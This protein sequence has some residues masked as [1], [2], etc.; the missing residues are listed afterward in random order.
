MP[1]KILL[2]PGLVLHKETEN[3]LQVSLNRQKNLTLCSLLPRGTLCL[4]CL[5]PGSLNCFH[6]HIEGSFSKFLWEDADGLQDSLDRCPHLLVLH[7]DK[8]LS[9]YEVNATEGRLDL[10]TVCHC[11]KDTLRKLCVDNHVCISSVLSVHLLALH[12]EQILLLI[13]N[14]VLLHL[15]YNGED[16]NPKTLSCFD[17]DLDPEAA[18]RISD[19]CLSNDILFLLDSSGIVYIYDTLDGSHVADM[20]LPLRPET[21]SLDPLTNIHVSPDLSLA[22][23]SS[24]AGW[25]LSL[26]LYEY[27]RQKSGQAKWCDEKPR[28]LP[29]SYTDKDDV[30]SCDG[31]IHEFGCPFR[32]DRS[33]EATLSSLCTEIRD[34]EDLHLYP[35]TSHPLPCSNC[36]KVPFSWNPLGGGWQIIQVDGMEE[37]VSLRIWSVS[38]F[39]AVFCLRGSDG[40]LTVVL[41]DTETQSVMYHQLGKALCVDCTPDQ[42][43]LVITDKGISLVLFGAS[44]DEFL[45][46]LMIHGSASNADTLC[47]LNNWGRCSIPIHTLEAGLENR[48]LDTVDFFLKSKENILNPSGPEDVNADVQSEHYLRNVQDLLP[49][50]DLLSSYIRGTDQETHSKHF[51][52]QLLQLTLGFL[53]G[54]LR[55]LCTLTSAPDPAIKECVRILTGYVT[56]LRPFMKR[57]TQQPQTMQVP[58][59]ARE[60][61]AWKNLS[62]EQIISDAILTNRIPEA[63]SFLRLQGHPCPGL[64]WLKQEGLKLVYRCL[65]EKCVPEACQLLRNMGFSVWSE[66]HRICMHTSER[67]VRNLLVDLLRAEGRLSEQ[68]QEQIHTVCRVEELYYN[69]HNRERGKRKATYDGRPSWKPYTAACE[70]NILE[71]V[72][73]APDHD[74]ETLRLY[75]AQGWNKDTQEAILL[76]EQEDSDLSL[77][78]PHI[79][80]RH[81]TLWHS[82]PSICSWLEETGSHAE[83]DNTKLTRWPRL[84][85][86]LVDENTM[87]CRY[88]RQK[89]LDKL[90]S[91]GMIVPS[92]MNDF[93]SLVERLAFG[94]KLMSSSDSLPSVFL[95]SMD[96]HNRFVQMCAENGLQYLLY[97]Y[98]DYYRLTPEFCSALTSPT[99]LE[100]FPWFSF[101]VQIRRIQDN[102]GDYSQ[103]FH[104]SLANAHMVMPEYLPSVSS[105]LLEGHTLLALATNMYAPGGI[106]RVL[107]QREEQ[108]PC[109]MNVDPQLLKMALAPYPKLRAALFPQHPAPGSPSHISLYH[110]LQALSPFNPT[111]FFTWQGANTLASADSRT[112]LPHCSCP[113]LVSKW[114]VVEQLDVCYYLR[115][116]RPAVAFANFLVQKLLK[117]KAPQQQ[118]QEIAK[119]VYSLALSCFNVQTVIASCVCFLELLGLSSHKLRVDVN[120]ADLILTHSTSPNDELGQKSEA[121]ALAQRMLRLV[122]NET[123]AAG[124]LSVS[125]EEAMNST[126]EKEW[127]SRPH[128]CGGPWST[129]TQFCLLHSVPLSSRYLRHCGQ[130]QDWLQLLMHT[131]SH[132]QISCVLEDLGPALSSHVALALQRMKLDEQPSC[133]SQ[134]EVDSEAGPVNLFHVMLRCQKSEKP[135]RML[136]KESVRYSAPL[137]SVLAACVQDADLISCLCVW[138]LTSV[139]AATC[140]VIKRSLSTPE[141]HVWDLSDLSWIWLNLLERKASRTLHRAFSIFMEDCPLLPLLDMYET[142]LHHKNYLSAEDKLQD[143]KRQLL[144]L[145]SSDGSSTLLPLTWIQDQVSELLKLLLL[146]SKT[147]YEQRKILQLLCDNDSQNVCGA[148]DIHKLSALTQILHDYPVCIGKEL[149]REYSEEG[150]QV[151]CQRLL[152]LLLEGKHFCLARKVAELAN[153]PADS[154]VIEEVL[155]D[156][157]LLQEIGQWEC[158][159]SRAEF[160]KKCQQMFTTNQ[161]SP[162]AASAFF[163]SQAANFSAAMAGAGEHID[164][165]AE[166]ELLLSLAGNWLSLSDCAQVASLEELEKLIWKCRIDQEVLRRNGGARVLCS[167]SPFTSLASEFSFSNLP[168]LNSPLL[169]EISTLPPLSG[170]P[171]TLDS[172][173]LLALSYLVDR[174]LDDSHVHEASR[175]CRYFQLPH[176]NLWLVLNCRAL[177]T[178]ETTKDQMHPDIQAILAEGLELQECVWKRRKRL[179]SSSSLEGS[180]SPLRSDPVLT[181]LEILKDACTHGKPFCL[182]LLCMY[183]LSQHLG[184]SFSD[185]SSRDAIDVLRSLISCRRPE[186]S[187]RAQAVISSHR[188]SADTVAKIVAEE[189]LRIW[190]AQYKEG[191]PAEVCNVSEMRN[192]FLQLTKLCP[193]P[194]L[195]GLTL[196]ENLETVPLTESQCIIELLISAHDCF[197]LTCHLEGIRRVLQ[198]CRYLIEMHLAPNQE[199]SLMVRLLSGIGRYNDM[200]Y[201]FDILHKSQHFEVLLRKQLDT[202]GGLQTALL[203]YIKRCHP[204][205]SEK[206]NMTAL[207][208]SLHRDI[209]HNH[210][211]AALIQLKLIQS[212]PWEYWMSERAE[213]KSSLMKALTLLIDAAESYSKDS[214]V[215]QSLRCARLTR[216][217]TLQIHLLNIGH[218]TRLINLEK[219]SVMTPILALPR[220]YQAVIVAEAYDQQPDWAEVLYHNVI[221]GGDFQYLE[222]F[223][224]RQ[225]LQSGV[226]E[227]ISNRCKLQ[228]PGAA[229]LQNL[230]RLISYC[231]DTYTQYKL[232]FENQFYDVTDV[233]MKDSQTRCCLTDMLSR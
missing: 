180:P 127:E 174:L 7:E 168:A 134:A 122:D 10:T 90:L 63:Q 225:L 75:W 41:F 16:V 31:G 129:I 53:N 160:W 200:V 55:T 103:I 35:Q 182:Q 210:E 179:Q 192:R 70:S 161:L 209:G 85:P 124:E 183:E 59:S 77:C 46:R 194:T 100:R 113:R 135:G 157:F 109:H 26:R 175:V 221:V 224:Q 117:S 112:E 123:K 125:L 166:E 28:E 177:A 60:K 169:F 126:L 222:E 107:E 104:A 78:Q 163:N 5:P 199:Y 67:S 20:E 18:D 24:K 149:L 38:S 173:A 6:T 207:C 54:Q 205:D 229:G 137:L 52:E 25:V 36:S 65:Q 139:D 147:S 203:E 87:C 56:G 145:Q 231:E 11:D 92:E 162:V 172:D 17:L 2:V 152:H 191:G 74:P 189:G 1:L 34:V 184:C 218:E 71:E 37:S 142:C 50:L 170:L 213:L 9:V 121:Q 47:L 154:L 206:H 45:T 215:R 94:N 69:P 115:T 64:T 73:T 141:D 150:L 208:F 101:L 214:C 164:H 97:T 120:V 99:L 212:Q 68:E 39:S 42:P 81:L 76:A 201:V 186:L 167:V 8:E 21:S 44:Q 43:C 132:Q 58:Q 119:D 171:G 230:K 193:D 22:V 13:N 88:T 140:A 89:I 187:D 108:T 66:L 15:D 219:E 86:E 220:F 95:T 19:V 153:L 30:S 204:G 216:L 128:A 14:R 105:M 130:R 96:F 82:W 217:L 136:L 159:Q 198:A 72:L 181:Y 57:F 196:L 62:V 51:S 111:H 197:S 84:T 233:L 202:K 4:T 83:K 40:N 151:E 118:I 32:T 176:R 12:G 80:W 228:P 223:K 227:Q 226:F 178:G 98:L 146:Q 188:L 195:V 185:I 211:Q 143:F 106:D 102:P 133:D 144:S 23:V 232:A 131:H 148:M 116:G 61:K 158:P 29:E 48:Q 91:V 110:L 27:F 156:Q 3:P 190:Q 165:L 33:W 93:E 138:I 49:A 79:L 114:A 155:Q